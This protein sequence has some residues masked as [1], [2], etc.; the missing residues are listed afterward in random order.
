[1]IVAKETQGEL[2]LLMID[3]DHFKKFNDRF[4]HLIGDEVLKT[5]AKTLINTLKGQDMVA[6]FGGEEFVVILPTT[7]IEGAMIVAESIR[8]AIASKELKRK[9][10]GES[11]GVITISMGVARFRHDSDTLPLLMK[12]AD[13]ALYESKKNG[14]NRVTRESAD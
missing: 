4:G 8:S 14:R 5:V 6:R 1:M 3:I 11:F 2:C 13:D 10:T 7:K 12:R 9:D